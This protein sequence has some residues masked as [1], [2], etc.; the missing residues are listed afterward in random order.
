MITDLTKRN[1]TR[2]SHII[3]NAR[4]SLSRAEIDIVLI[5]LTAI[6]KSDEDF[7]DYEFTV[8]ELEDKTNRQWHTKQLNFTTINTR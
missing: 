7:K 1:H 6:N 5:L 3:I 8:K 4:Y 2:Q